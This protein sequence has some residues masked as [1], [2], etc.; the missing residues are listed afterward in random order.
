MVKTVDPIFILS[1]GEVPSAQAHI[2]YGSD[3]FEVVYHFQNL[4]YM[5]HRCMEE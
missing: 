2:K 5:G 3:S 1:W 4:S